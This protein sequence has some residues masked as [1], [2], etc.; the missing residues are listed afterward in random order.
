MILRVDA[1]FG[2]VNCLLLLGH[3]MLK[4]GMVDHVFDRIVMLLP[5]WWDLFL[6]RRLLAVSRRVF[7]AT[8]Y[9]IKFLLFASAT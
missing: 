2:K 8:D 3:S 7:G 6:L 9:H 4:L 5:I 1:M